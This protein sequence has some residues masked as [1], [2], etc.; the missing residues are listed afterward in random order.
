MLG[1]IQGEID[2]MKGTSFGLSKFARLHHPG[3]FVTSGRDRK[4][5]PTPSFLGKRDE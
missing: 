3:T 5:P 2:M 1:G 4:V